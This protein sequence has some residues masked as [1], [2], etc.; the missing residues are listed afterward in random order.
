MAHRASLAT[1]S[2]STS[3]RHSQQASS[4]PTRANQSA[5]IAAPN[6]PPEVDRIQQQHPLPLP[7]DIPIVDQPFCI[8]DG[9]ARDYDEVEFRRAN[10]PPH[11]S[12]LRRP[13]NSNGKLYLVT[14]GQ[15]LG[16]FT[17]W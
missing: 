14:V 6:Q 9:Y 17:D 2:S 10:V 8:T 15:E 4:T 7:G 11:P 12:E 13:V 3:T 16:I 5:T 1:S